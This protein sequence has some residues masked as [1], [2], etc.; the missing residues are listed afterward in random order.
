MPSGRQK[1]STIFD[2]ENAWLLPG[3]FIDFGTKEP[4]MADRLFLRFPSIN[5]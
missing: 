5:Y 4:L 2:L 1:F 3:I